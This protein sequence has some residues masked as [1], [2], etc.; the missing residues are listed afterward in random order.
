[1]INSLT[2]EQ[3]AEVKRLL[4]VPKAEEKNW[5]QVVQYQMKRQNKRDKTGNYCYN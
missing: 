2:D 3:H 4:P 5:K 1:M